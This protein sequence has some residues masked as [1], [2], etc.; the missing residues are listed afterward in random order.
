MA[1]G[2]AIGGHHITGTPAGP[3]PAV[4]TFSPGPALPLTVGPTIGRRFLLPS[5]G[6]AFS[7]KETSHGT[8]LCLTAPHDAFCFL[9]TLAEPFNHHVTES[10]RRTQLPGHQ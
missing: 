10:P 5:A 8:L 3:L 9:F 6:L 7:S 1:G 4:P 2:D